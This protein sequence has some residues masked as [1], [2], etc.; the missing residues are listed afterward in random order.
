MNVPTCRVIC[1]GEVTP[2]GKQYLGTLQAKNIIDVAYESVQQ[3]IN[4]LSVPTQPVVV[5][6]ENTVDSKKCIEQLRASGRY[7]CL[8]WFGKN[9][10]REDYAFGLEARVYAIIETTSMDEKR[11]AEIVERISARL[12][13]NETFDHLIHS[14]K[15]VLLQSEA[16]ETSKPLVTEIKAAVAKLEHCGI[17]NEMLAPHA[18][19]S[20]NL[21]STPFH[22]TQ[23]F[24][25]A[26]SIIHD[27]ERTGALYVRGSLP[28]E[29][30]RVEF[31]QGKIVSV[32]VDD[33]RGEKALYRMF[34]WDEP[35]FM[36]TRRDPQNCVVDEPMPDS[37]KYMCLEGEALRR[38]YD[39][40]RREIPPPELRLVLDPNS[41]HVGTKL[42]LE[43]FS[44]L[45]S[46]IEF[47]QVAQVLDYNH[48][49]DVAIYGSLI[50]LKKQNIIRVAAT[51]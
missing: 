3:Y 14:L 17:N 50:R 39:L 43:E 13:A 30:G 25:D 19:T 47:S 26:L 18:K 37:L 7:F 11:V 42:T 49:S 51:G 27:L 33:V 36:F 23:G 38:R 9:F 10:S 4:S 8:G 20:E 29:Q 28:T 48:L 35:R 1:V 40:I 32:R 41:L 21:P 6:V 24:G 16:D 5:F 22:K 34:L 31:L 44:T 2:W 15:A 45:T 46:V 12:E